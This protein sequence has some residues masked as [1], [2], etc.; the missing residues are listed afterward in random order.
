MRQALLIVNPASGRGRALELVPA[1]EKALREAGYEPRVCTTAAAGDAKARAAAAGPETELL[2]TVGGDGTINEALNG[3][4]RP[5]PIA[6]FPLGTANVLALELGLPRTIPGFARLLQGGRRI[7]IDCLRANGR[8]SFFSVGAGIDGMAIAELH[9]RRKGPIRKASYVPILASCIWNYR[10]PRLR[11]VA[12]GKSLEGISFAL[13]ANTRLYGGKVFELSPERRLDDGLWECYLF[14][15][16]GRAALLR[17]LARRAFRGT[18]LAEGDPLV[19]RA[20]QIRVESMEPGRQIP[21]Q[22]DGDLGGATPFEAEVVPRGMTIL[23]PQ[24]TEA[25]R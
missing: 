4:A 25:Q 12:D 5:I 7:T 9:R 2:V 16:R 1:L 10:T 11:V 20:R 8:L 13:L 18:I 22:V 19:L 6:P 24:E 14:R 15:G 21:Y 3:L 17:Y 23:V